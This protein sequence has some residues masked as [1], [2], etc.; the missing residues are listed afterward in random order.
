MLDPLENGLFDIPDYENIEDEAFPPLPPP[1]S[2]GGLEEND[3]DPFA[4]GESSEKQQH[5]FGKDKMTQDHWM[6]TDF[7]DGEKS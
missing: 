4:N 1:A 5:E 6:N 3:G 7:T 2:P